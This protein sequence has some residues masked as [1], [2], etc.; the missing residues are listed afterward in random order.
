MNTN[1]HPS[2]IWKSKVCDARSTKPLLDTMNAFCAKDTRWMKLCAFL[3]N[4][5]TQQMLGRC[6]DAERRRSATPNMKT[7]KRNNRSRTAEKRGSGLAAATLL[8]DI[9]YRSE[10]ILWRLQDAG[11]E[12]YDVCKWSEGQWNFHD[13]VGHESAKIRLKKAWE[14][15][16]QAVT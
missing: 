8:G 15:Y 9:V 12:S 16:V 6:D 5:K 3:M 11:N 14:V 7:S 10:G 1:H 4:S 2:V 13:N